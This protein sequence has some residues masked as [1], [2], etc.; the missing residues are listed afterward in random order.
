MIKPVEVV[1]LSVLAAVRDS[2][3]TVD[4]ILDPG[5]ANGYRYESAAGPID[6]RNLERLAQSDHLERIFVDRI[7]RCPWCRSHHL[8]MREICVACKSPRIVGVKLLHHFRCGYVGPQSEFAADSGGRRCPKCNGVLRD[9]GTDHDVPGPHFTCQTCGIFFQLPEIG[10]LCLGC[11]RRT[12]GDDLE[13]VVFEDVNG[14]RVSP[15]GASALRLGYLHPSG[16]E[17]L[18]ESDVPLL[19][20]SVLMAFLDDER[21]RQNRFR[22]KFSLLVLST[23]PPVTNGVVPDERDLL[24]GISQF[25]SETD[26]LGRF[27][28]RHYL[29]LLPSTEAKA[30]TKLAHKLSTDKLPVFRQWQLKAQVASLHAGALTIEG[31]DSLLKSD[32]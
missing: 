23:E 32:G 12:Q 28:E 5:T 1:L 18:T 27:D 21:R 2:G 29:V 25:L 24:L 13:K 15:F 20:R 4:P 22:S 17:Q 9:R 11:R 10:A 14:Y 6:K 8:N 30:A 26:K 19:R 3:G 16:E 7:S 31:L